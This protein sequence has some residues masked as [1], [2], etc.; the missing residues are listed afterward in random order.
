[1]ERVCLRLTTP[2]PFHFFPP[3][4]RF[5]C[6]DKNQKQQ[7]FFVVH[8]KNNKKQLVVFFRQSKRSVSRSSAGFS[9]VDRGANIFTTLINFLTKRKKASAAEKEV[10]DQRK[11]R[12]VYYLFNNTHQWSTPN[13]F[14]S[15]AE[16]QSWHGS[17]CLWYFTKKQVRVL[18][19]VRF[20]SESEPHRRIHTLESTMRSISC[21]SVFEGLS[22]MS[23]VRCH[24]LASITHR[25]SHVNLFHFIS[26][27]LGPHPERRCKYF[28]LYFIKKKSSMQ[29]L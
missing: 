15:K 29:G 17:R 11:T 24:T 19:W 26:S 7:L 8:H 23:C 1:M 12:I 28:C 25:H 13:I 5:I 2:T 14:F 10:I 9:T 21:W 3:S 20:S 16:S 18:E 6:Y 4:S 22:E 27:F